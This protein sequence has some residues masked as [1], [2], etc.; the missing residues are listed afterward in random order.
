MKEVKKF[1]WQATYFDVNGQTFRKYNVIK[2]L[3]DEV[4]KLKKKY[5]TK[6]EFEKEFKIRVMSRYWSKC[7][8]EIIIQKKGDRIILTPWCGGR[9][10]IHLD[11]TDDDSFDWDGFINWEGHHE[12]NTYV[13]QGEELKIDVYDQL[14]FRWDEFINYVWNFHHKYQRIKKV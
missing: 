11:V 2:N 14:Q 6:E 10:G 3:E 1:E 7:E 4:K 12:R 8:W 13:L 5:S 9:D